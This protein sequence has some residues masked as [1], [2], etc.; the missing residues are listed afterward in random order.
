MAIAD[1]GSGVAT[2]G[3]GG[4][5]ATPAPGGGVTMPAPGGVATAAPDDAAR[6]GTPGIAAPA[7]EPLRR[8]L[9]VARGAGLRVSAAEGIDA[10]RA[11]DIVGFSDRT[12]LKDT[13]GLLLAKTPEEKAAYDE[14]FDIYFKRDAFAAGDAAAEAAS[15]ASEQDPFSSPSDGAGDGM[16]GNGMGG[17]GGRSLGSLLE[18]DD[19]AALATG[20]ELAARQSGVENIRFFTQKNLYARRI[21]ERMGLRALEHD[22]ETMRQAGTPEALDRAQFLDGRVEALRDTVRDFVERNLLLFA[23]GDTERFREELLKSARFSNLERRDLDRMRVLVRQM[24]K[25]LAARYAKTRRRR[26][27]GQLDTRRT[28]RRNMGW[29]GVPFITV[30]KQ[31]RIDKPRVMVL[32]DVSGSV[33]AMAQ[34]LLM[35]MYAVNEALSD[36]RSFAFA[37]SLIEVS[38]IL[39]Q[40]PVE[41]AIARIMSLIGFGSSNYG[42]ALADFEEG[43]MKFVTNKTTVIILGD[44]RGNRTDPQTDVLAHLSQRSRRI[45]WLNPE[46][47]SAWGTGDSDMY[48]YAPFCSL[49]TVCNT[50]RQLERVIA[51][52]LEDAA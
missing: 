43:W 44:A 21:L 27:R 48:R 49:V 2:P 45:I 11:V 4:G 35:F 37:G 52:I 3:P 31:K 5:V 29:G 22:M 1:P 41:Q 9:Q 7:S 12:V 34:F 39:E 42:N 23:K 32:C 19:R 33:A 40:Q 36:I 20:M 38:E 6:G 46:Y 18:S 16:G 50:L 10:A 28:L 30:W 26:L 15:A 8:F 25:K 14:V 17:Q 51:D 47:R 24:A 13:L